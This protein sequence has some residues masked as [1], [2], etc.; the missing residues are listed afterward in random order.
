MDSWPALQSYALLE[1]VDVTGKPV[2]GIGER[3][4][5]A[6]AGLVEGQSRLVVFDQDVVVVLEAMADVCYP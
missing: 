6:I 3:A 1:G 2:P 4:Y 5:L